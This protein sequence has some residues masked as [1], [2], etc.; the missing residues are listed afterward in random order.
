MKRSHPDAELLIDATRT[1]DLLALLATP[2]TTNRELACENFELDFLRPGSSTIEKLE[3]LLS[4][5]IRGKA[6]AMWR[7][8]QRFLEPTPVF[9]LLLKVNPRDLSKEI[10]SSRINKVNLERMAESF[11]PPFFHEI[12]IDSEGSELDEELIYLCKLK[13]KSPGSIDINLG[14]KRRDFLLS[15]FGKSEWIKIC[16]SVG[17]K[18]IRLIN[19]HEDLREADLRAKK[20]IDNHFARE[21]ARMKIQRES[22]FFSPELI[23]LQISEMTEIKKL[24]E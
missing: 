12:F 23:D 16:E 17:E 2:A 20:K 18:A 6:Y 15:H 3:E 13:Y 9:R 5:D 4:W 11:Y 19:N 21:E 8:C 24:I 14:G 1:S 10:N 22:D 7:P